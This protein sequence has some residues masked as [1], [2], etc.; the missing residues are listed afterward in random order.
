MLLNNLLCFSEEKCEAPWAELSLQTVCETGY[1]LSPEQW[2][3]TVLS[4]L[5]AKHKLK[6][7]N[8]DN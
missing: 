6:I 8:F 1:N 3:Y 2:L 4:H 7:F 5:C